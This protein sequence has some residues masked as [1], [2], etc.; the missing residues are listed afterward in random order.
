VALSEEVSLIKSEEWSVK[1]DVPLACG[2]R[3]LESWIDVVVGKLQS[4]W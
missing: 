1:I 2:I 4:M 3:S